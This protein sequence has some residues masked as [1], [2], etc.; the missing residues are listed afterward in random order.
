MVFEGFIGELRNEK[1]K[2]AFRGGEKCGVKNPPVWGGFWMGR[3]WG[4]I[5]QCG[6]G[7]EGVGD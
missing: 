3:F 4:K 7:V 2:V 1:K 5:A 6:D